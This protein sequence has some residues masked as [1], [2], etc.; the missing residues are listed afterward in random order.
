VQLFPAMPWHGT[1]PQVRLMAG[2]WAALPRIIATLWVVTLGADRVFVFVPWHNARIGF[3]GPTADTHRR[4][5]GKIHGAPMPV[6]MQAGLA[7]H[8]Y[9]Y[10]G[11]WLCGGLA[12]HPLHHHR[13]RGAFNSHSLSRHCSGPMHCNMCIHTY[14]PRLA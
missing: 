14:M 12:R 5:D 6:S 11:M 7:T 3:Q 9:V 13:P 2:T 4:P 1:G 10:I 8:I